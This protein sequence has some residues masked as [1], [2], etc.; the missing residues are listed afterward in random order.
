MFVKDSYPLK[1]AAGTD[2]AF[3]LAPPAVPAGVNYYLRSVRVLPHAALTA[4]GSN[5]GTLVVKGSDGSTTIIT[6]ATSST[7]FTV[8]TPEA[9]SFD[10]GPMAEFSPGEVAKC[11]WANTAS[12]VAI[13]VTVEA[14]W[15]QVPAAA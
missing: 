13:D 12:G 3:I 2:D 9:Q 11:T 15:E 10:Q 5:Y 1:A 14:V 6:R 8:S 7:G 4:D